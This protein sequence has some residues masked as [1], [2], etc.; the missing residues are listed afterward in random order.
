MIGDTSEDH[1]RGNSRNSWFDLYACCVKDGEEYLILKFA[2]QIADNQSITSGTG[3]IELTLNSG[4]WRSYFKICLSMYNWLYWPIEPWS[5]YCP[6]HKDTPARHFLSFHWFSWLRVLF[7]LN[8]WR[9]WQFIEI[10]LSSLK[11]IQFSYLIIKV[12]LRLNMNQE[13]QQE[14]F[15][16]E[17]KHWHHW[18]WLRDQSR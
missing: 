16:S 1:I 2:D 11:W 8:L 9:K 17:S 10:S 15:K 7:A 3:I 12:L 13:Q 4:L 18:I 5:R 14:E 6:H